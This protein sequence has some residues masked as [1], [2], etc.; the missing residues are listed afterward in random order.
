MIEKVSLDRSGF[1]RFSIRLDG[2]E[3]GTVARVR[4][5]NVFSRA[6]WRRRAWTAEV[7]AAGPF[8]AECMGPLFDASR[9]AAV[10]RAVRAYGE[11]LGVK[12]PE[13]FKVDRYARSHGWW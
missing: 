9:D 1:G 13:L 6:F 4:V 8:G 2:R 11:L 5:A 10:G 7:E 3:I 12:L